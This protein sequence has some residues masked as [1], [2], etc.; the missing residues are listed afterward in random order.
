MRRSSKASRASKR[1]E[2]RQAVHD[3]CR[4]T[5]TLIKG[6]GEWQVIVVSHVTR[7]PPGATWTLK[8]SRIPR[9][10]FAVIALIERH[11]LTATASSAERSKRSR[12]DRQQAAA[13]VA[14]SLVPLPPRRADQLV[15]ATPHLVD[16]CARRACRPFQH[17]TGEAERETQTTYSR[18]SR[19]RFSRVIE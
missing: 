3:G 12:A 16:D 9:E 15:R 11:V 4:F 19:Q 7:L 14:V 6:K 2:Q 10:G 5:D 1:H 18:C 13:T 8:E 17:G